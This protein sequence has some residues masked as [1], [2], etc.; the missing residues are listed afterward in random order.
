MYLTDIKTIWLICSFVDRNLKDG[1]YFGSDNETTE[2][3]TFLENN[4]G[5]DVLTLIDK[6]ILIL[7]QKWQLL[8]PIPLPA[9]Y[10]Q[11]YKTY[12]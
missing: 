5:L 6:L 9:V 8:W 12:L 7:S 4:S 11:L 10:L 2:V 3:N 1:G